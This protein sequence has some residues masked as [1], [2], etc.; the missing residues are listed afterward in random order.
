MDR[1]RGLVTQY[2]AR[3]TNHIA[4]FEPLS[5]TGSRWWTICMGLIVNGAGEIEKVRVGRDTIS[6]AISRIKLYQYNAIV[7]LSRDRDLAS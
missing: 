7:D 3:A 1:P 5:L 4:G 2:V 6:V